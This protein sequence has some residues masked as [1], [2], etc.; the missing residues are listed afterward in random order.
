MAEALSNQLVAD[1]PR[2][3]VFVAAAGVPV[4][5]R[6]LHPAG[7]RELP[8]TL[9]GN[10]WQE[11]PFIHGSSELGNNPLSQW[12]GSRDDFGPNIAFDML[13]GPAGGATGARGDYLLRTLTESD[14]FLGQWGLMRV[15][16]PGKDSI[17]ITRFESVGN[18]IVLTGANTVDPETGRMADAV[19]IS[20]GPQTS[21]EIMA[22]VDPL[23][24]RWQVATEVAGP[25][26]TVKVTSPLHGTASADKYVNR[27]NLK[28]VVPI[29]I[30][31]Q[32][33]TDQLDRFLE[34]SENP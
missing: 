5:V 11:E 31:V 19:S 15:I 25:P 14:F 27:Q 12:M 33:K 18:Q 2:T 26:T 16:D 23:T 22:K 28:P 9:H 29:P 24:G 13:L 1:D 34:Q 7:A 32:N 6:M 30:P 8:I 21:P 17:T 20:F 3:P 4:R 10:V